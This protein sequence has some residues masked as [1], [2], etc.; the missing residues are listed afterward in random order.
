MFSHRTSSEARSLVWRLQLSQEAQDA[1]PHQRWP[2]H[3][4][5]LFQDVS[6]SG[7]HG[8]RLLRRHVQ[9]ASEGTKWLFT[10][11]KMLICS[12]LVHFS[13]S[14]TWGQ[15]YKAFSSLLKMSVLSQSSVFLNPCHHRLYDH[16]SQSGEPLPLLV[17][18]PFTPGHDHLLT[19]NLF[20]WKIFQTIFWAPHR[21]LSLFFCFF[22]VTWCWH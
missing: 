18:A 5:C 17:N 11:D 10:C 14:V 1:C 20:T 4:W 2:R 21:S 6:H 12:F 15:F 7:L 13:F 22:F 9:R 16:V 3:W 8:D 19:R